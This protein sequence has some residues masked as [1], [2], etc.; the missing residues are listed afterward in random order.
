MELRIGVAL[1]RF[2]TLRVHQ[3]AFHYQSPFDRSA[4]VAFTSTGALVYLM[5][6]LTVRIA[7]S[8]VNACFGRAGGSEAVFRSLC[9]VRFSKN[10][11]VAKVRAGRL[12][13]QVYENVPRGHPGSWQGKLL[14]SRSHRAGARAKGAARRR[15]LTIPL[16]LTEHHR[17][18]RRQRRR[19]DVCLLDHL[20]AWT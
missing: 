7:R 1:H 4:G 10:R 9:R 2:K 5:V 15:P 14:K 8:K 3:C 17:H 11:T 13:A 16:L 20:T 12:P 6:Y 19:R 18:S